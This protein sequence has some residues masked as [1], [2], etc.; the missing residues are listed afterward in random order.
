VLEDKGYKFYPPIYYICLP[1]IL[2]MKL[3][4]KISLVLVSLFLLI[5]ISLFI[6]LQTTKPKYEDEGSLSN[7]SKPTTVYFDDYGIPHI[8]AEN[9][10][11]AM[12]TLGYVHAQDSQKSSVIQH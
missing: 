12:T 6:Y 9:Q 4:K 2:S 11:D 1:N 5:A 8:Y 10:K 3:V 7:L